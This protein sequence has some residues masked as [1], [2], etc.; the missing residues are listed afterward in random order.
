MQQTFIF[1]FMALILGSCAPKGEKRMSES[2]IPHFDYEAAWKKV[3]S[4]EDK[5]LYKS[6][7]KVVEEIFK[8]ARTEQNSPQKIKALFYKG[9]FSNELEEDNLLHFHTLLKQE[10]QSAVS[11]EKAILQS[12]L[13][14]FYDRY[15]NANMHGFKHRTTTAD[16]SSEDIRDWPPSRFIRASNRLFLVSIKDP[17]LPTISYKTYGEILTKAVNTEKM[18][19]NLYEIL[20]YRALEHFQK[21]W[22]YLPK[23]KSQLVID[24]AGYFSL[25]SDFIGMKWPDTFSEDLKFRALS[26]FQEIERYNLKTRDFEELLDVALKRLDWVKSQYIKPDKEALYEAALDKLAK[27]YSDQTYTGELLYRKARMWSQS[28]GKVKANKWRL[29]EARD[30]CLEVERKY[31]QTLGA[32]HCQQLRFFLEQ[33]EYDIDLEE[34]SLPGE[35]L[36]LNIRY[37]LVKKMYFKIVRLPAVLESSFYEREGDLALELIAKPA[38][39]EWSVD[40]PEVGDLR[41]HAVESA[42]PPLGLGRYALIYSPN[43]DFKGKEANMGYH[44]FHVSRLAYFKH[45]IDNYQHFLVV[46]RQS[47]TPI[48]GAKVLLRKRNYKTGKEKVV[49]LLT[50]RQGKATFLKS[51]NNPYLVAVVNGPDSL[52]LEDYI[53]DWS[54][55]RGTSLV[56]EKA[57][58]FT[59]RSIY[60]PGQTVYF[61]AIY[62]KELNGLPSLAHNRQ[63]L[64]VVLYD[65]NNKIVSEKELKVNDFSSVNGSF[66]LPTVG[67]NGRMNLRVSGM[68]GSVSFRVEEYK[69]PKFEVKIDRYEKAYQLG[70]TIEV[71][72]QALAYTGFP[73]QAAEGT[74]VVRRKTFYPYFFREGRYFPWAYSP[75]VEIAHGRLQTDKQGRFSLPVELFAGDVNLSE[76]LPY[77]MY[78]IAVDIV[79]QTGETHSAKSSI[80][81]G[82]T[83]V[84]MELEAKDRVKS[85]QEVPIK[86]RAKNYNS[87]PVTAKGIVHI[88][89]LKAPEKYY[90]TRYWEV[91]DTSIFDI[92]QFHTLFPDYAYTDWKRKDT[93]QV[94]EEIQTMSFDILGEGG[95]RLKLP[96]GEYKLVLDFDDPGGEKIQI[97]RFVSVYSTDHNPAGVLLLA[98]TDKPT[99]EP[100]QQADLHLQ[101]Q[102]PL[103]IYSTLWRQ[104]KVEFSARWLELGRNYDQTL[105]I[106]KEHRGGVAWANSFVYNNRFYTVNKVL[107]VPWIDKRLTYEVKRFRS[108]LKPGQE[109]EWEIQVLNKDSIGVLAEV[110]ASMYD[111]SLDAIYPSKWPSKVSFP[112]VSFVNDRGSGFGKSHQSR[113]YYEDKHG[114]DLSFPMVYRS[115]N[116]FGFSIY[117]TRYVRMRSTDML[118]SS[119]VVSYEVPLIDKASGKGRTDEVEVNKWPEEKTEEKENPA[120]SSRTNLNETVFFYPDIR[121]DTKGRFRL[122]FK[123]N[124]ALTRWKLRIFS[125]DKLLGNAYMEKEVVTQKE[126]MITPNNPRFVREGDHLVFKARIDNMQDKSLSGTAR[127]ELLNASTMENVTDRFV[128]IDKSQWEAEA[129]G[130]AKV[131]WSMDVPLGSAALLVYR[132]YAKTGHF[133][134]AEEGYLPVLVNKKLVTETMP[135]WVSGKDSKRFTLRHLAQSK[136]EDLYPLRLTVEATSHPAWLAIQSL[137]HLDCN[138]SKNIVCQTNALFVNLLGAKILEDN[139]SIRK[140]LEVWKSSGAPINKDA[141]LSNLSKNQSLKQVILEETP[142]VLDAEDEAQQ[143]RNLALLFDLNRLN[144]EANTAFLLLKQLQNRQG[145]FPWFS[146]GKSNAYITRYVLE[147]LGRIR[148]IRDKPFNK[149]L[150]LVLHRAMNYTQR[151]VVREYKRLLQ[152]ASAGKIKMEDN[153][154]SASVIH[155]LYTLGFYP[156]YEIGEDLKE[157]HDYYYG[158]SAMYWKDRP[159][160]L[161]GML[162]L[163]LHRMSKEKIAKDILQAA[164]ERSIRSEELGMY[165]KSYHGYFWYQHP[166][167]TQAMMIEA[168]SKLEPDTDVMDQLKVWLLKNKQT[169]RWK[170]G[171]ATVSAVYALLHGEGEG[172]EVGAPVHVSVGGIDI[173]PPA[174]S[175]EIQAGTGYYRKVFEGRDIAPS[176]ANI[177]LQNPNKSIAW[178]GVY[179]QYLQDLDKIKKSVETP[180]K[181]ERTLYVVENTDRG[182]RMKKVSAAPSLHPGDIVRVKIRIQVDRPME[183]VHLSDQRAACFEPI[184]PLSRYE[185]QGGL[186][187]YR[188]PKDTKMHFFMDY[189]PRGVFVLE[190]DLRVMQEGEFSNGIAELQSYYAPEFS[191]HSDGMK[192]SVQ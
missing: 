170:T 35:H 30:L 140:V 66:T 46:D 124:E 134:D 17:A 14:E 135:L 162:A 175:S 88:Y 139:P 132:V 157:V 13:G 109:V 89:A 100:S 32:V 86:I 96:K 39:H 97:R 18:R 31:P 190:Y 93:W 92:Q 183:F 129:K 63:M 116:W 106:G 57:I 10:I 44:I 49:Q 192:I 112:G 27:R 79:D 153:H 91:P 7:S 83:E 159:L 22:N 188:N 186:G 73:I 26:L 150:E 180:L 126:L 47:G 137:S 102:V 77:F 34:V 118:E 176:M 23:S 125:H 64:K 3:D 99:Y 167:E 59:D 104:Y 15:L 28:D 43:A 156:D 189:L 58:F 52:Y 19:D 81:A 70:D 80:G 5:R 36:L 55:G 123:M 33:P 108:T 8:A 169:H 172:L 111:L 21:D 76:G 42:I 2:S 110:V 148:Q 29:K 128:A 4:L 40:L 24:R 120:P 133:T 87:Q 166:V 168:F 68:Q 146:G 54:W 115:I 90:R 151:E 177:V 85:D 182:E 105:G 145:G 187:Y 101:A 119:E 84:L 138:N 1:I 131:S 173:T 149:G 136:G 98:E 94:L 56:H 114:P 147:T 141:L 155:Y 121:T 9:K 107:E 164:E 103:H 95:Y 37:K 67:L 179:W 69:R 60:R 65:A 6:A 130:S 25:P 45:Y 185:W 16:T 117:R 142:W 127:I 20:A 161:Q 48:Q 122:K 41:N 191:S 51:K 181:L 165:W 158:Q 144:N 62:I 171:K 74:Y 71:T 184:R 82:A 61:K 154:L 12:I 11:P 75:D 78:E 53:N 152:L 174:E 143:K 50:D 38:V 113:R 178:G 72:G 163:I 160:Y